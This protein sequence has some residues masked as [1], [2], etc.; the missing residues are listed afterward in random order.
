MF[1]S[2]VRV[3][4]VSPFV[5]A[6]HPS[7]RPQCQNPLFRN[8][9]SRRTGW[10]VSPAETSTTVNSGGSLRWRLQ[11]QSS[12]RCWLVMCGRGQGYSHL[13]GTYPVDGSPF[14]GLEGSPLVY[15]NRVLGLVVVPMINAP[16]ADINN[17]LHR[18][19]LYSYIPN[20]TSH[21][22]TYIT[23][24]QRLVYHMFPKYH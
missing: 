21:H 23:S 5:T 24:K 13:R 1:L 18:C 15:R 19:L 16:D 11:L 10:V 17:G 6:A 3:A 2:F 4:V 7:A 9:Y 8:L 14:C 12:T 22:I 20:I